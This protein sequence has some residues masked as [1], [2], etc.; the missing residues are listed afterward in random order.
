MDA[1]VEG[2]TYRFVATHLEPA[3][4]TDLVQA[5]QVAELIQIFGA[6][7]RPLILVGDLNTRADGSG[8]PTYATL[9]DAGYR[10]V[11]D[12][13]ATPDGSGATCCH[14]LDLRSEGPGL[15]ERIDFVMVRNVGNPLS[16]EAWVVGDESA[17]R[18][19]SGMWPSDHAGVMARIFIPREQ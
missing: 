13:D 14:P 9:L 4:Y 2:R 5:A 16:V 3:D 10:D 18:T 12:L 6:E 8:T 1:T 15:D 7:T 19:P 11:W 17:D